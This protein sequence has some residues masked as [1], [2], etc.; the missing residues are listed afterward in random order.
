MLVNKLL[1]GAVKILLYSQVSDIDN[2]KI[3]T[4]GK[5]KQ[6]LTGNIP[7]VLISASNVLYRGIYLTKVKIVGTNIKFDFSQ[8]I[9][10]KSLKLS[11]PILIDLEAFVLAEDLQKS[12]FSSLVSSGLTDIWYRFLSLPND[13]EILD[14]EYQNYQWNYLSFAQD[15]ITFRGIYLKSNTQ[16]STIEIQTKIKALD[17]HSLI[18]SPISINTIP[19]LPINQ[20]KSLTFELGKQVS[21]KQLEITEKHLLIK[22]TITVYP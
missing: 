1:S 4:I 10:Q 12:V 19:A 22:G 2:L 18:L 7:E 15:E 17:E 11:E 6:I 5:D 9:S 16:Q 8:V 3:K 13:I 21:I 14:K 20:A